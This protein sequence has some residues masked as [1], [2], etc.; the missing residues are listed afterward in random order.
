MGPDHTRPRSGALFAVNM[1]VGTTGGGT[2]A[3]EE[4]RDGLAA[5]GFERIRLVRED[6]DR[7]TGLVEG[8]TPKAI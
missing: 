2:Y 8:F 3:F 6:D 4:I 5:A 7:M 1:L